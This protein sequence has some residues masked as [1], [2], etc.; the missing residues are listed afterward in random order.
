[1]SSF[2]LDDNRRF[3]RILLLAALFHLGLLITLDVKPEALPP[4]SKS[5]QKIFEVSAHAPV[6]QPRIAINIAPQ[7]ITTPSLEASDESEKSKEGKTN[8]ITPSVMSASSNAVT[9]STAKGAELTPYLRKRTV[10]AAAHENKDAD[11]LNRWQTYVEQFGND[12]YPK[13]ALKNNLQGNLRLLV[14]VNKDGSLYEVS[15]RQSSGSAV[16]DEAA[17]KIVRQSA[18]FEPL[19]PEIAKDVDVLEIIRTWQ[20]RGKLYTS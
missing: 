17:I 2:I 18:P 8:A 5:I 13:I 9:Q 16:L 1:M 20:F 10:S 19:P 11:Y 12:H 4:L 7:N 3:A 15:I 14:A 6:N